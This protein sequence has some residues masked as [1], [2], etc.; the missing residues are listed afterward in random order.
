M[1]VDSLL[2]V[3]T[4]TSPLACDLQIVNMRGLKQTENPLKYR[5][6]THHAQIPILLTA[7]CLTMEF[8]LPIAVTIETKA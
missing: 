5:S 8:Q 4:L 3:S 1:N 2:Q 7:N 6:C